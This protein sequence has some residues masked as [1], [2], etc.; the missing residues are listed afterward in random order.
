MLP[1][2]GESFPAATWCQGLCRIHQ[3]E[4]CAEFLEQ[5]KQSIKSIML[6]RNVEGGAA[7]DFR[8]INVP[9][10]LDQADH[11][12]VATPRGK[13]KK[14]IVIVISVVRLRAKL[15][16]KQ[17]KHFAT[18]IKPQCEWRGVPPSLSLVSISAP[19]SSA[20]MR[21]TS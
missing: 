20:R 7:V 1:R 18:V 6:S 5:Y 19:N 15:P 17:E 13:M 21:T 2:E 9:T 16:H 11:L 14:D 4:R 12:L 8:G 3:Q 10:Q